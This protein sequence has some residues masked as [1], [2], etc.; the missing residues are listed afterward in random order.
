MKKGPLATMHSGAFADLKIENSRHQ[1][2]NSDFEDN[3]GSGS[4]GKNN[5]KD[6]LPT[7]GGQVGKASHHNSSFM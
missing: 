5:H 7:I 6:L 4:I 2:F 1:T 3:V